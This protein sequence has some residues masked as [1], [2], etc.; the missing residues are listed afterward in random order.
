MATDL[1][2][3]T[4]KRTESPNF[5]IIAG[6]HSGDIHGA[7]LAKELKNRIP[8]CTIFGIGGDLMD[9]EGVNILYHVEKMAVLGFSEVIKH[10]PF[11]REV[12][13]KLI[14][15]TEKWKPAVVILIDYPGFNIRFA[16]KIRKLYPA[17]MKILYYISPQVWAWKKGRIKTLAKNLDSMAVVLPFEEEIYRGTGLNVKFVGHPLTEVV[18]PSMN[19]E[20]FQ[21]KYNLTGESKIIGLLPGSRRQEI[22]RHLPEMLD[23]INILREKFPGLKSVI[24]RPGMI[25]EDFYSTFLEGKT[26]VTVSDET[27]DI[28]HHSDFIITSSGTATLETALAGTPMC[29]IYR[30]SGFS[31]FIAKRLVKLPYIG[32]ANI[33]LGE[34]VVPELIQ[35]DVSPE[36]ISEI[37]EEHLTNDSLYSEVKEKLKKTRSVLGEPGA[38]QKVA[39][40]VEELL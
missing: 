19:K 33:V 7:K 21:S 14:H 23:A 3:L 24:G 4:K 17:E 8:K 2:R 11:F 29:I 36:K 39:D 18:K 16:Q 1:P 35:K 6:E 20:E 31:F 10:L 38:E 34:R 40:M 30:M 12:M 9:N 15:E 5:L 32:L 25:G 27:Y 13:D 22:E 37:V 26:D 28:M